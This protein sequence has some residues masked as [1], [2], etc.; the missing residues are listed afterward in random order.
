MKG[1]ISWE[2]VAEW[3]LLAL[4]V[5]VVMGLGAARMHQLQLNLFLV[6]CFFA[7]AVLMAVYRAIYR[8]FFDADHEEEHDA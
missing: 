7:I 1:K 5:G 4:I 6:C 8:R 2:S 3:C